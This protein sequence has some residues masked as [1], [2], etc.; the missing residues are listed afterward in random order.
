MAE[1][2]SH[3]SPS[4]SLARRQNSAWSIAATSCAQTTS[5]IAAFP[6]SSRSRAGA[7][8][9]ATSHACRHPSQSCTST[10]PRSKTISLMSDRAIPL[11]SEPSMSL[12]L[13]L[14]EVV[15]PDLRRRL[16]IEQLFR[17]EEQPQFF[18]G[19]FGGIRAVDE[20]EAVAHAEVAA[21]RA[22]LGL[23]AE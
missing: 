7:R 5:C 8:T 13:A 18:G 4:S 3:S 2:C 16:P 12:R 21:D 11:R 20:V 15:D 23:A 6:A 19:G 10:R 14:R 1:T 22:G 9:P 17:L